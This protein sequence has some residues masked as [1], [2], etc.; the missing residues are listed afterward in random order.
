MPRV[1]LRVLAF[2]AV[3]LHALAVFGQGGQDYRSL[4]EAYPRNPGSA[5]QQFLQL[6]RQAIDQGVRSCLAR[7]CSPAQLRSAAMLHAD[8]A[9]AIF[10]ANPDLAFA[11]L[12]GGIRLLQPLSKDSLFA[13]RWYALVARVYLANGYTRDASALVANGLIKYPDSGDLYLA[14]GVITEHQALPNT[15]DVVDAMLHFN[16]E[17]ADNPGAASRTTAP[18]P[19]RVPPA[20]QSASNDYRKAISLKDSLPHARLRLGWIHYLQRD[21]RAR[22]DLLPAVENTT[23]PELA[24]LGHL[25][26]GAIAERDSGIASAIPDYEAARRTGSQFP[27]GCVALSHAYLVA[28]RSVEA[29]RVSSEC[30]RLE[31]DDRTPDPWWLFRTG[32]VDNGTVLWLRA[33]AGVR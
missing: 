10:S 13:A 20:L 27:T 7:S 29:Y 25:F 4:V 14:R 2:F 12:E 19:S 24:Y 6:R 28:G 22:A 16:L 9:D 15:R 5:V 17:P 30:L 8:A 1:L 23:D 26:L 33:Q 11:I 3:L 32:F 18:N 31:P 21:S